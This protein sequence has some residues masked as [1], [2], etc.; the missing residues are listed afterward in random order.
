MKLGWTSRLRPSSWSVMTRAYVIT[1]VISSVIVSTWFRSGTFIATGDMGPFIRRGWSAEVL[2]SWNHQV[3]GAGSAA[4]TIG[5][6]FEF[7]LIDFVGLFGADETVAQWLFYTIFYGMV[8]V[9]TA[10]AA[11]AIVRSPTAVVVAGSFA[12]MNGFFLTRIP[13][14]LNIISV[15]TV[16][17]FTGM[18]LRVAQGRRIPPAVGGSRSSPPRSSRSTP[19]CSWWPCCGPSSA[20]P[21]SCSSSSAAR[22]C[23]S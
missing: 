14:P 2:Y 3:S 11:A 13:N 6:I 7:F 19:R 20:L 16:A 23:G 21:R 10:Y 1:G 15:G 18:A 9:G 22:V 17:I 4:H 12:V 8:A 5:R